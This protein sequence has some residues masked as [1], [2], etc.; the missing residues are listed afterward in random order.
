MFKNDNLGIAL[1]EIENFL[2]LSH[3]NDSAEGRQFKIFRV[4]MFALHDLKR[5]HKLTDESSVLRYFNAIASH[6]PN[7][8]ALLA[9]ILDKAMAADNAEFRA[10]LRSESSAL[11]EAFDSIY[12]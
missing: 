3:D 4:V 11:K 8:T 5:F 2:S 9:S 12:N 6:C 7:D 10:T 1:L